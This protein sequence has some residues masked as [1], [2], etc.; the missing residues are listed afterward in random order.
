M[1]PKKIPPRVIIYTRDIAPMLGMSQRNA[2]RI[3]NKVRK[4]FNKSPEHLVTVREFCIV[5]QMEE[6][7]VRKFII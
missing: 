3:L 5:M 1:A 2:Q 4:A 6:E 7:S